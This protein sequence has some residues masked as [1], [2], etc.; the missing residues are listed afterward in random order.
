MEPQEFRDSQ[1]QLDL[2]AKWEPQVSQAI[3][4]PQAQVEFKDL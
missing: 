4:V 1:V 3:R 2:K